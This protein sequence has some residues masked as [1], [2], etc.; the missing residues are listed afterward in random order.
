MLSVY[1]IS[2]FDDNYIWTL[3]GADP[4]QVAVV[5]PGDA[6]PVLQ[7][8]KDNNKTLAAI[9]I[10]HHHGDHTGGVKQ[11][12]NALNVPVYGPAD[13][14]FKGIT[15][16]L[17]DGDRIELLGHQFQVK[18]VPAHTL[19][20]IAYLQDDQHPQLFCGDTLFLAGCGRL[21]EGT[22][23][24]ML[25]A[26]NYFK[27]LPPETEVYCTHEYSLANLKFA[28]AVE[29]QNKAIQQALERCQSSRSAGQPTLPSSI[30]D[31]L[32]FNPYMRV[33][34]PGVITSAE[35]QAGQSLTTDV[36]VLATIREWKNR[37]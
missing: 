29:P 12:Q 1:P 13:S 23:E 3:Q 5:D 30:A 20:H 32:T 10:T 27:S 17:N 31:E 15:E 21:F 4:E 37:F 35:R 14:P 2:A 18:A 16:T 8:L 9:L 34:E 6:E 33:T 36:A 28:Q 25:A 22:A 26:M 19:D 24:Q 11:L 7:Y